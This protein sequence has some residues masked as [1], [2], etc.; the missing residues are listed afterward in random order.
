MIPCP[1]TTFI[2]TYALVHRAVGAGLVLSGMFAAGMIVTVAAFPLLAVALRTTALPA[3]SAHS[4]RLR[5]RAVRTLEAAAALCDW[6]DWRVATDGLGYHLEPAVNQLAIGIHV[7]D[8]S[9]NSTASLLR[10]KCRERHYHHI[11]DAPPG[12]KAGIM[13]C[14]VDDYLNKINMID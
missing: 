12:Y 11:V 1:L 4:L 9:T 5:H 8:T 14:G 10:A 2:M 3:A 7:A 6:G 13:T